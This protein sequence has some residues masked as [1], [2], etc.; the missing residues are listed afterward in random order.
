M[1]SATL[2]FILLSWVRWL[3]ANVK[4][5][6]V[7]KLNRNQPNAI[8]AFLAWSC[9]SVLRSF[10]RVYSTSCPTFFSTTVYLVVDHYYRVLI[11]L[12]KIL[13]RQKFTLIGKL[14]RVGT[15]L[16]NL[17]RP[18]RVGRLALA[19][20]RRLKR[21]LVD[22]VRLLLLLL[23]NSAGVRLPFQLLLKLDRNVVRVLR[24]NSPL[25]TFLFP[26]ALFNLIPDKFIRCFHSLAEGLEGQVERPPIHPIL[27]Q[28]PENH[29]AV[30]V[31]YSSLKSLPTFQT[32]MLLYF[33]DLLVLILVFG[34][35]LLLARAFESSKLAFWFYV[36]N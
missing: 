6:P 16:K 35:Q 32:V 8:F 17:N 15:R 5:C 26:L 29:D 2:N 1:H 27:H 9:V 28:S 24:D 23:Y 33:A 34:E 36:G 11:P 19:L 22:W 4:L 14:D 7:L 31:F 10:W 21:L 25:R 20:L 12:L 18:H 3:R 13:L 30:V